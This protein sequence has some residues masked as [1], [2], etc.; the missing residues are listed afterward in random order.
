MQC[1]HPYSVPVLHYAHLGNYRCPA[2]GHRR[3]RPKVY[4][5][6]LWDVDARGS[7]I[8]LVTPQG[9]CE[10]R[11]QIPGLYNVYNALAA[12]AG[13]VALGLPLTAIRQGLEP[14]TSRFRPHG[15]DHIGDRQ[16]FMALVKN[17]A[18]ST[19]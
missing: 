19:R 1:G 14:R 17:P 13:A 12:A 11:L 5:D 8:R 15:A 2:C 16:V 10:V 3:P 18:A 4:V 9:A 6:R 7:S